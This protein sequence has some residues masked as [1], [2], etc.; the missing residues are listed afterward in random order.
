MDFNNLFDEENRQQLYIKCQDYYRF[1]S[2]YTGQGLTPPPK[3]MAQ[4]LGLFPEEYSEL[5]SFLD[6]GGMDYLIKSQIADDFEAGA[7]FVDDPL[8]K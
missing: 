2:E 8:L 7:S 3:E 4:K 5:L 6:G 1:A